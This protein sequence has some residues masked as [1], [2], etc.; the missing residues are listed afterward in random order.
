MIW[1]LRKIQE[2]IKIHV[3]IFTDNYHVIHCRDDTSNWDSYLPLLM[4]A[5]C[6]SVQESTG[7]TPYQLV[8]GREGRLPIDV[9]FGLPPHYSMLWISGL[10]R[11]YQQV[12]EYMG[13][14][15]RRQKVHYDKLCNGKP[16]KIGDMVWLH[17]P[18]VP[19]GKSP[20]L[21]CY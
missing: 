9:M 21:H 3:K 14:Q 19:R 16:F 20:K 18:A 11:A 17:C 15:Q 10:D 1:L 5:Y 13:L 7:C 4:F 12:R 2:N 8:F 6:T